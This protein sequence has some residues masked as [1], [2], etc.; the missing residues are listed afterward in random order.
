MGSAIC[1]IC[2]MLSSATD[3][4]YLRGEWE[5]GEAWERSRRSGVGGGSGRGVGEE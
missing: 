3:V 4:M 2:R 5:E 1:Q